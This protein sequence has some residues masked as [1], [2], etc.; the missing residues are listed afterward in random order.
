MNRKKPL[1]TIVILAI[2]TAITTLLWVGFEV[3]RSLTKEP[4]DSVPPEITAE[5]SPSLDLDTLSK[6][7]QRI[8]LEDNEIGEI[9]II[10]S[11]TLTQAPEEVVEEA[12]NEGVP[13]AT[14]SGEE[15]S[16]E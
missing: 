1:P 13:E 8:Y 14:P 11:D 16:G 7:T 6:V 10:N 5:L 3:Y 12:I 15:A 2:L 4:A 9:E